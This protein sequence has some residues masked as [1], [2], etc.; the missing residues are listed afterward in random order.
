MAYKKADIILPFILALSIAAVVLVS[1]YSSPVEKNDVLCGDNSTN[2]HLAKISYI[3]WD[4]AGETAIILRE[5]A[6]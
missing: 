1:L 2:Q 4:Y 3:G 5:L 6:H